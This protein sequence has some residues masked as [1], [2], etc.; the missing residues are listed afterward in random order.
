MQ[1]A[2]W[3]FRLEVARAT[4][5]QVAQGSTTCVPTESRFDEP[6]PVYPLRSSVGKGRVLTGTV[7]ASPNCTPLPGAQVVFWLVNPQGEYDKTSNG[8]VITDIQGRYRIESNDPGDTGTNRHIHVVVTA[9][10]VRRANTVY[11]P[12][13]DQTTGVFDVVLAPSG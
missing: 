13:S 10:G 11:F 12:R 6:A 1:A 5:N 4:Q 8:T 3:L 7:R 9:N 2:M